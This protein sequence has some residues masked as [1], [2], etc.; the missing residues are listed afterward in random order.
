MQARSK[1]DGASPAVSDDVYA[2]GALLYD[3]L[4]GAPPLHPAITP[5]R[6]RS[7]V[8][9]RPGVDGSG[10]VLPLAL[11]QLVAASLE[12]SPARRPAG[13]AA[14]RAVLEELLQDAGQMP[15]RGT[16]DVSA[17]T[18]AATAA[19]PKLRRPAT[20]LPAWVVYAGGIVLLA[21][22][23]GVLFVLPKLVSE[24]P[25]VLPPPPVA[26]APD[27]APAPPPP[28]A[29]VADPQPNIRRHRKHHPQWPTRQPKHRRHRLRAHPQSRWAR[30]LRWISSV[31][32]RVD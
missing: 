7:E 2:L 4:T 25:V 32:C 8:P 10:Q 6:I 23:A 28:A 3:L 27:P 26:A 22:L 31:P 20:G 24:R 1:L 13:M 19:P 21:A 18:E 14:V 5:E 15:G 17:T 16:V 30:S 12:K 11:V 29:K 9:A